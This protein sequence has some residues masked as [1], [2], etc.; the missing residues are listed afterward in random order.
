MTTPLLETYQTPPHGWTCFHCGETFTSIG[1]AKDHFGEEPIDTPICIIAAEWGG[2]PGYIRDLQS[3][4]E[5]Y[6]QEDQPIMRELYALGSKHTRE[7][8]AAEQLGYDRGLKDGATFLPRKPLP[9][10]IEEAVAADLLS[11]MPEREAARAH[12]IT[13]GRSRGIAKRLRAS[14][15][16]RESKK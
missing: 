11:G 3:E 10:E 8:L 2:L 7:L 6:R 9:P 15:P 1:K 4:L 5:R 16:S 13:H 12:G 14:A